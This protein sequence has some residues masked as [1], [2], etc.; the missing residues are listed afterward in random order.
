LT[1]HHQG[2]LDQTGTTNRLLGATK[3][4]IKHAPAAMRN[5][6]LINRIYRGIV[7]TLIPP[8]RLPHV[9]ISISHHFIYNL[10]IFIHSWQ[11]HHIS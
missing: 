7:C 8:V 4:V 3:E 2:N 11:K 10:F 1:A 9:S 6:P 5:R